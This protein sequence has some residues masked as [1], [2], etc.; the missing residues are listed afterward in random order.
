M[1]QAAHNKDPYEQAYYPPMPTRLTRFMRRC[2]LWQVLRFVII[3]FKMLRL[4]R[5]A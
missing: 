4:M 5:R 2:V 1:S 3:N